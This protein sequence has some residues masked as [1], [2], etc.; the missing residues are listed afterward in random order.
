MMVNFRTFNEWFKMSCY[1]QD[2]T[3]SA[4]M[5]DNDVINLNFKLNEMFAWHDHDSIS[6]LRKK[7]I[8]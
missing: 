7:R 1:C 6:S 5:V 8:V 3:T 4:V 2:W